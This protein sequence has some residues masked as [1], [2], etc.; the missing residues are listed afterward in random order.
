MKTAVPIPTAEKSTLAGSTPDEEPPGTKPPPFVSASADVQAVSQSVVQSVVPH[1]TYVLR[2]LRGIVVLYSQNEQVGKAN[3]EDIL[4]DLETI[5]TANAVAQVLQQHTNLG[6]HLLPASQHVESKLGRY[7]PGDYL[8]FN[9]FEGVDG[10]VGENGAGLADEEARTAFVLKELG[11]RFTGAHGHTL[12]LAVNKAQTKAL[13][14]SGGVLTP[15]WRVFGHPD[16]VSHSTLGNLG[17]P[18]MVKPVAEDSSLAIDPEAVA[19]DLDSLRARVA[20]IVEQYHQHA[21]V[22]SFIDGREFNVAIWGDPPQVLPLAEVD[23]S[24]FRDPRERI[25]SFAAKW[26]ETSFEYHHTP[27][28][29]PAIVSDSLAAR[30]RATALR[31]WELTECCGYARVDMRVQDGEIYVLEVNPNPSIAAD[32]GFARAAKAAGF[33]YPQMI[34]N[35]LSFL[36]E[37]IRA[38]CS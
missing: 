17:F 14:A 25:V 24:A 16:E 20:Y 30:I 22:E 12:A 27:V 4:A 31:C 21:L 32:A 5:A 8:V 13:L 36:G 37:D 3:S 35:I 2:P 15:P 29:C 9:L 18:L 26:H 23:L 34:L 1:P 28:T 11:Y 6:V 10:L 7:P 19:I 38:H 33:D